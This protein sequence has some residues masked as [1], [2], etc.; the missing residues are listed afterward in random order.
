MIR[1]IWDGRVQRFGYSPYSVI[2]SDPALAH[3]HTAD[4]ARMPSRNVGTPYLP[5][6]QLFFRAMVTLWDSPLAMKLALLA[7][8][9]LT[10]LFLL[11]WLRITGRS[12]WLVLA[13]AWNPLVILESAHSS[14]IDVLGTFWITALRLLAR[15]PPNGPRLLRLHAGR[16]DQAPSDRAGAVVH[17]QDSATGTSRSASPFSSRSICP[18]CRAPRSPWAP[19]RTSWS[20]SASTARSSGRSRG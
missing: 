17:R 18:S 8:D 14:H 5:A 15:R 20:T 7:L 1:Y 3:T 2:P 13:Y 4:T 16:G 10:I 9:L 6:A 11:R 19:C 12:E